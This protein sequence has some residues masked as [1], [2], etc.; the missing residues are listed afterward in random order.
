MRDLTINLRQAPFI[1]T[2]QPATKTDL[3]HTRI[4]HDGRSSPAL[5]C[6]VL[7]SGHCIARRD[8]EGEAEAGF[9]A[10]VCS[11]TEQ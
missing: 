11:R 10:E 1:G 3:D 4:F 2:S 7:Q 5:L 6:T 8:I 9:L